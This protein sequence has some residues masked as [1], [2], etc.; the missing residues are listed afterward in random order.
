MDK[1]Q[2]TAKITES[3]KL[4]GTYKACF[5]DVIEAL[6]DILV[7]RDTARMEFE[8]SG[9]EL[10]I[11]YTNKGGATNTVKNP[12]LVILDELDKTALTYW[13]DLGLTPAGLKRI[14]ESAMKGKANKTTFN[15]ILKDIGI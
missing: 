13:R 15:D 1:D 2:W 10:V 7:R 12:A 9:G 4:A 8:A 3:A 5:D 11:E 6:A 14:N